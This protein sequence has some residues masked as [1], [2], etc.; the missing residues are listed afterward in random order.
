MT[1]QQIQQIAEKASGEIANKGVILSPNIISNAINEALAIYKQDLLKEL[2]SDEDI[3]ANGDTWK[4]ELGIDPYRLFSY[5]DFAAG[6]YFMRE[7]IRTKL[8]EK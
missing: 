6:E 7:T 1:D 5:K 3:K 4:R 8:T 2:P